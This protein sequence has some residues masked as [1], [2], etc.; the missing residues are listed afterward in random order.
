MSMLIKTYL[1]YLAQ[2]SHN[3]EWLS[4]QK[5]NSYL[6]GSVLD[7]FYMAI[8]NYGKSKIYQVVKELFELIAPNCQRGKPSA[9]DRELLKDFP[10][11]VD[12][13]NSFWGVQDEEDD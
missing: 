5:L 11:L 12:A 8:M 9:R 2:I 1:G 13:I 10:A 4:M 3:F 6:S 7:K